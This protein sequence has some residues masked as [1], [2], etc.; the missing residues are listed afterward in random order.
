MLAPIS[1][2]FAIVIYLV[3]INAAF[4]DFRAGSAF[5]LALLNIFF[6]YLLAVHYK[7]NKTKV[8]LKEE[9][10]GNLIQV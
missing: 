3:T 5:W 1:H 2:T 7:V 4:T 6:N 10:G 8:G 9:E